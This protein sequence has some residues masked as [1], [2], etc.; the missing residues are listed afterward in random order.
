MNELF[1]KMGAQFVLD[2]PPPNFVLRSDVD[3]LIELLESA[4][5]W[6]ITHSMQSLSK[7][8]LKESKEIKEYLGEFLQKYQSSEEK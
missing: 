4:N 8:A 5:G 2:N 3:K 7:A 1:F 6:V